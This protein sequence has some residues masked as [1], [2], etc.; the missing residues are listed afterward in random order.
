MLD[1]ILFIAGGLLFSNTFMGVIIY[2]EIKKMEYVFE[3]ILQGIST[4]NQND[5]ED[6]DPD[7]NSYI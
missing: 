3:Q 4:N 1:T 7:T 6:Y 5:E 2:I